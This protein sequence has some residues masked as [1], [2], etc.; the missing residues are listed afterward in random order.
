MKKE[1]DHASFNRIYWSPKQVRIWFDG[2][3]FDFGPQSLERTLLVAAEFD[4]PLFVKD[5]PTDA[6]PPGS[7]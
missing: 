7:G 3:C 4:L 1:S 2:S 5:A 6:K